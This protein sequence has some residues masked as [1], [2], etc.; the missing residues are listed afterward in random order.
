MVEALAANA[1]EELS[2]CIVSLLLKEP[3]YGHLL[4]GIV[5]RFDDST[6][7][8]AVALTERGVELRISPTFFIE[9]LELSDERTAVVK[10]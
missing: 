10:H 3:F 7:T 4:S 8:A 2:R 9:H 6:G 5:R 1:R